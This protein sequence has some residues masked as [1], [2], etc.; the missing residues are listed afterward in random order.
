MTSTEVAGSLGAVII[1]MLPDSVRRCVTRCAVAPSFDERTYEELLRPVQGPTLG[2]LVQAGQV[3]PYGTQTMR[4]AVSD[5]LRDAALAQWWSPGEHAFRLPIP[6]DLA[7]LAGRLAER[8]GSDDRPLDQLELSLL[9]G[10]VLAAS[11]FATLYA[12]AEARHDLPLCRALISAIDG[13]ERAQLLDAQLSGLVREAA[14]RLSSMSRW[15]NAYYESARY[16]TREHLERALEGLL[17]GEPS[18]V[19]Q[20]YADG[21]MGKTMQIRWLISRRCARPADRTVCVRIDFDS[22]HPVV[23]A[24]RPWLLLIEIAAQLDPQLPGAPFQEFLTSYASYRSLLDRAPDSD[25]VSAPRPG[26]DD[27]AEVPG[28]FFDVL[29]ELPADCRLLVVLDTLEEAISPAIDPSQLFELVGELLHGSPAVRLLL[30]GRWDLRTRLPKLVDRLPAMVSI[31]VPQLTTDEQRHYLTQVRGIESPDVVREIV[32]LSEGRPLT[33][34]SYANLVQRSDHVTADV[35]ASFR[36]PG[37]IF[38][39][40]RV[41]ER[42]EDERL[43]WLVRYGVI[44]RKLSLDFV[45]TVLP[46]YLRQGMAG[47]SDLDD[48]SRDDRPQD[49]PRP[50]FRTGILSPTDEPDLHDLWRRLLTYAEDYGWVSVQSDD[51]ELVA[52]RSEVLDALRGLLRQHP[53]FVELQTKAAEYYLRASVEHPE[54]RREVIYHQSR[55]DAGLGMRSWHEAVAELRA[56]SDDEACLDLAT[57]LLGSDYVD[58]RGEPLAGFSH[59]LVAEAQLE[60]ARSAAALTQKRRR[61][62]AQ[63]LWSD[64]EEGVRAAAR[65]ATREDVD[66]P[67]AAIR[68]LEAQLLTVE[69]RPEAVGDLLSGHGQ[70]LSDVELAESE[71]TLGHSLLRTDPAAA[72]EH[73]EHAYVLARDAGDLPGARTA[74]LWLADAE[75]ARSRYAEAL[76]AV[77]RGQRDRVVSLPDDDVSTAEAVALLNADRPELAR[78][79]LDGLLESPSP[80]RAYWFV[81]RALCRYRAMDYLGAL[82]DCQRCIEETEAT[83]ATFGQEHGIGARGVILTHLLAVQRGIDDLADAA[84]RARELGNLSDSATFKAFA[85]VAL[86]RDVGDLREAQQMVDEARQLGAPVGSDGW[87]YGEIVAM[88]LA[89][90]Q[91]RLG[92]ANKVA[93]EM[94]AS[95]PAAEVSPASQADALVA[96]LAVAETRELDGLLGELAST[97]EAI[98][99]VGA[100]L[101]A[102]GGLD[103][104]H[105]L[106]AS[107]QPALDRLVRLAQEAISD[108][109]MP[110]E[111]TDRSRQLACLAEVLR[112]AGQRQAAAEALGGARDIRPDGFAWWRWLRGMARLGAAAE[113]E[114]V[115]ADDALDSLMRGYPLLVAAYRVSLAHRRLALDDLATTRERLGPVP[116]LLAAVGRPT[117]WHALFAEVEALAARRAGDH[118]DAQVRS[119]EAVRVYSRLGD[120]IARDRVAAEFELGEPDWHEDQGTIEL[121]IQPRSDVIE[122]YTGQAESQSSR[123]R[124]ISTTEL[125]ASGATWRK[126]QDSAAVA[127]EWWDWSGTIGTQLLP[128]DLG[129]QLAAAGRDGIEIRLVPRSSWLGALPWELV[130]VDAT[131]GQPLLSAPGVATMYRSLPRPPR[132]EAKVRALQIALCRLG[133][134]SGVPDGYP[135]KRTRVALAEFQGTAGLAVEANADRQ[136]WALLTERLRA[137]P[138]RRVRVLVLVPGSASGLQSRRRALGPGGGVVDAYR[139]STAR[140]H[141][142]DNPTPERVWQYARTKLR[143]GVDLVHICAAPRTAR[144]STVLDFGVSLGPGWADRG[145]ELSVTAVD[146]L[147]SMLSPDAFSPSAILDVPQPH[148]AAETGRALLA[149]NTFAYQ[150]LRLGRVPAILATGLAAHHQQEEMAEAIVRGIEF[151]A[152][153]P[154]VAQQIWRRRSVSVDSDLRN[155]LPFATSALF[156]QRPPVTMLPFGHDGRS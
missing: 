78:G 25:P 84:R 130:R 144:G 59:Q 4:F 31:E 74:S 37:L 6:E 64:V 121:T 151:G 56:D 42:I 5:F 117:S 11:A 39:L 44:P 49:R 137:L 63:S 143:D 38:A 17:A 70:E 136:T 52:F 118:A 26:P 102:L 111:E 99:P 28:R 139:R 97:L 135:G 1:A 30:A 134:F 98:T 124:T 15:T 96:S 47:T 20:F 109:S 45:T 9:A 66:L 33:V 113:E 16:V 92:R 13:P 21:G 8:A 140:V 43:Q 12:S 77:A 131:A 80:Y 153:L 54:L 48:P 106:P 129:E 148:T 125:H 2:E 82:E 14:L 152:S 142:L 32:R 122:V 141:V 41:V 19:V 69:G 51:R 133:H 128:P 127:R 68:V 18:R 61:D 101:A 65:L 105:Q 46:T 150:L 95:L 115:A 155:A 88:R 154:A 62:G 71:R 108:R 104:V 149:R 138:G 40:E 35:L 119:A 85:G 90:R 86:L 79:V 83:S 72:A 22:V 23:V 57:D 24:R 75:T 123:V 60:R 34:A 107:C 50:I 10:P 116:R 147:L 76:A 120:S 94:R 156:L 110:I 73:L 81:F 87:I 91:G 53:I 126:S 100:R 146:E 67:A 27:E 112:V 55:I 89:V 145:A 93:N 29:H 58:W 3:V 132:E 114:A 103:E 7:E 36:T